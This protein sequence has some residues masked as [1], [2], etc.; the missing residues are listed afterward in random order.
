LSSKTLRLNFA[1]TARRA[2]GADV[3]RSFSA[4]L[5]APAAQRRR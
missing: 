4:T 1:I 2:R 3:G 5:L